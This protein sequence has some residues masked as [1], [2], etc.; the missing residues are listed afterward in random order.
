M[1]TGTAITVPAA[2]PAELARVI[3]S[4]ESCQ[5]L[6][7]GSING[8]NGDAVR[9]VTAKKLAELSAAK[10]DIS[11]IISR[12]RK[13]L[14]YA[15][16]KPVWMLNDFDSKGMPPRV[17][18]AIDMAGTP[19]NALVKIVPG[20]A[21]AARLTRPSTSAGLRHGETGQRFPWS[22]GMHDYFLVQDGADIPRAIK[23]LAERCWLHQQGWILIGGVGQLLDRCLVDVGVCDS[24][25]LAFEDPPYIEPPLLQ[26]LDARACQLIDGVAIDTRTVVPDLTA[27][28]RQIVA[29]LRAAERQAMEPQA[30]PIRAAA[31]QRLVEE[32]IARKGMPRANAMRQV[33]A[34][35]RGV[36]GPDIEL[37]FDHHGRLTVEQI[38]AD[39]EKYIGETLCDPMEGTSYCYTKAQVLRSKSDPDGVFVHTFAHG[40]ATYDLRHD[41]RSAR[42]RLEEAPT[43]EL[44]NVLC[45]V[46]AAADLEEN[47]IR[48]LLTLCV[49]RAPKIGLA[50]FKRRLKSDQKAP[51]ERAQAR[52]RTGTAGRRL[53]RSAFAPPIAADGWPGDASRDGH[54]SQ[55]R[56]R[57]RR[58]STN[59]AP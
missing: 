16:G 11:G 26:N 5:A 9:V 36:L 56:P 8:G 18:A 51:G 30:Q 55:A 24:E 32:L 2:N 52:S 19:W 41:I 21:N 40:R 31:D 4:M 49:E 25:H 38:L 39:P 20:L 28:E 48:Q 54:R 59:A 27:D 29:A 13:Y 22:G 34:R 23:A 47:E 3:E 14:T 37:T 46:V 7:M 57:R 35:H 44:G 53:T 43:D 58:S 42:R 17:R 12:T 15:P 50:V 6:T 10:T 45:A 33:R 1:A